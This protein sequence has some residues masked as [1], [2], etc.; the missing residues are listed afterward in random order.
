[1]WDVDAAY[2]GSAGASNA[3]R[4]ECP[5]E[6]TGDGAF[7]LLRPP[8][9]IGGQ[10]DPVQPEGVIDRLPGVVTLKGAFMEFAAVD[11]DA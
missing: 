9:L 10:G 6:R 7:H 4:L 3:S 8:Q 5:G 11:L 2:L 1:M